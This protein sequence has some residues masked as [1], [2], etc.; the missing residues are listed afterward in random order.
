MSP[1]TA[2]KGKSRAQLEQMLQDALQREEAREAKERKD[3]IRIS[4]KGCVMLCRIRKFGLTFYMAE[5]KQIAEEIEE[6]LAF[7]DA[8]EAEIA[9]A[10]K[11]GKDK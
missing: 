5:W 1:A 4:K 8:N 3:K 2:T 6:V 10:E 7:I 9:L 11:N